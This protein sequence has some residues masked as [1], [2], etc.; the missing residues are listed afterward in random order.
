[1]AV[2][3]NRAKPCANVDA[4]SAPNLAMDEI[5]SFV[6]TGNAAPVLHEIKHALNALLNDGTTA[7]IDLG[8]IPFAPG[9]ERIL[10]EMLGVGE[11][12]AT[13]RVMG[14][15]HVRETA[16]AGVWRI[17][18]LNESGEIQS[19]FIEITLMPEILKTQTED[20]VM[21]LETLTARL[22]QQDDKRQL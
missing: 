18:H 5:M 7:T 13:L 12:H 4:M 8:A 1:V 22:Q 3:E 2:I 14:E 9:D 10:D 17:D 20:A 6:A 15:S 11:V 19:R 16:I 21:G